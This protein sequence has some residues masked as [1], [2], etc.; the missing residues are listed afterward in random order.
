M[1]WSIKIIKLPNYFRY[2]L[3]FS[4]SLILLKIISTEIT[5]WQRFISIIKGSSTTDFIKRWRWKISNEPHFLIINF[6]SM[7]QNEIIGF[8]FV[9]TDR[10][11]SP[12]HHE[13]SARYWNDCNRPV[14]S[15]GSSLHSS[16][17]RWIDVPCTRTRRPSCPLIVCSTK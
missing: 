17:N 1:H 12:L 8:D 10:R 2:F 13:I 6:E 7:V 3:N 9:V 16:L 4:A 14:D 11:V 5:R 15:A